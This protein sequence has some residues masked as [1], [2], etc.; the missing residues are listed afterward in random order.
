VW[1][2]QVG[3]LKVEFEVWVRGEVVSGWREEVK[4]NWEFEGRECWRIWSLNSIQS[5]P[6]VVWKFPKYFFEVLLG[7]NNVDLQKEWEKSSWIVLNWRPIFALDVLREFPGRTGLR[8]AFLDF[9]R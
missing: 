7:K 4:E 8:R 9:S 3:R 1:I 6:S 2:F 5:M